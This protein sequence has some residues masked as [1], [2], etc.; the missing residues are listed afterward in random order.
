MVVACDHIERSQYE[1]KWRANWVS[2]GGG[3]LSTFSDN[4]GHEQTLPANSRA[5]LSMLTRSLLRSIKGKRGSTSENIN[6][7]LSE[8]PGLNSLA[9]EWR[10]CWWSCICH[11]CVEYGSSSVITSRGFTTNQGNM[12]NMI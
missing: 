7:M 2:G 4:E 1:L 6:S 11:C 9:V 12:E 8:V 10:A 3:R 5:T